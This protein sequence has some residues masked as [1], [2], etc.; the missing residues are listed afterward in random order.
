[1]VAELDNSFVCGE[2]MGVGFSFL[3]FKVFHMCVISFRISM[4]IACIQC[5]RIFTSKNFDG[6]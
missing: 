6:K 5:K 3:I 2:G 1:M 4:S